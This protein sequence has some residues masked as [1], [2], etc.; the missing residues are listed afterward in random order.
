MK[1]EEFA[2]NIVHILG[3]M[4]ERKYTITTTTK[5]CNNGLTQTG[6]AVRF[7]GS[8]IGTCIYLEECYAAYQ[9]EELTLIGAAERIFIE[10]EKQQNSIPDFNVE[11][12]YD[13]DQVKT[14]IYPALVNAEWNQKVLLGKPHRCVQDLAV[15]YYI[16]VETKQEEIGRIQIKNEHLKIWNITEAEL[17]EV[18]IS[19]MNRKEDTLFC[20]LDNIVPLELLEKE[21]T[22][23]Y[24]LTNEETCLGAVKVI[25]NQTLDWVCERMGENIVLLPSSIHEFLVLS[26]CDDM[27]YESLVKTV[28]EINREVVNIDERL[29]DHLYAY[30]KGSGEIRIVA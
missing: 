29:S 23:L 3:I 7:P 9:Q 20:K 14:R 21:E 5:E 1:I 2:L 24:L 27:E 18:A 11:E 26:D 15:T 10:I 12:F 4:V 8:N 19:N 30:Q 17:Y 16:E 28:Q 25:S 13:F 22:G 6:I